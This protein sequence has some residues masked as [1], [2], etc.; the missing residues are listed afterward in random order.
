MSEHEAEP[1]NG[2]DRACDCCGVAVESG[3]ETGTAGRRWLGDTDP[4]TADLPDD[5]RRA[6]GRLLGGE[7]VGT[8]GWWVEEIKQRTGGG[9]IGVADLC[10]ADGET[11]HRGT[12]DGETYHFLCFY[13]AVVLAALTGGAVDIRTESPGGTVVEARAVGTDELSVSPEGAA[14]S[15]G[16]DASTVPA[17]GDPSHADVYAA[18]CPYVRAFPD[19]AAY[20]H[21]AASVD[22]ATVAMPLSGATDLADALV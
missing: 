5:V 11:P 6:L 7:A 22:A 14:F 21:W 2:T 9:S 19:R 4:M 18:V 8:L 10:H 17:D 13:D 1:E 16:A 12:V 20:E 15:F 3:G